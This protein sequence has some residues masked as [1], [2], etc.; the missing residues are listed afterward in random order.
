MSFFFL[1]SFGFQRSM[2]TSRSLAY[3]DTDGK[4]S[5]ENAARNI[6][7]ANIGVSAMLSGEYSP[8]DLG[9]YIQSISDEA[10]E[11]NVLAHGAV[12]LLPLIEDCVR[13][14]SKM[15]NVC[16]DDN[17]ST[18][19]SSLCFESGS[20]SDRSS[21]HSFSSSLSS[22]LREGATYANNLEEITLAALHVLHELVSQC[23]DVASWVF[24][25]SKPSPVKKSQESSRGL[26]GAQRDAKE[27]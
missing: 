5:C 27:V 13:E 24:S 7:L 26:T 21:F 15:L 25:E 12:F 14:Y 17:L 20:S 6:A 22:L 9:R 19:K 8:K 3:R 4:S 11:E 2:S 23:L 18:P 10:E 1:R 16:T